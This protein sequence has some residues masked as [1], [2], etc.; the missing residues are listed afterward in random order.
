MENNTNDKQES[1]YTELSLDNIVS[2]SSQPRTSFNEERL[3]ELAESIKRNGIIQ[4]IIVR[5]Y[6]K[7]YE[8]IAGERRYRAAK[9]ANLTT[10][11]AIIRDCENQQS[12]EF[13]LIENVQRDDLNPLEEAL[14]YKKLIDDYTYKHEDISNIIGKSRSYISNYL[15][16]LTLPDSIKNYLRDGKISMGHAKLLVNLENS[17]KI[18][19]EIIKKSLNVRQ[20]ESL[21]KKSNTDLI[22]ND[23]KKSDEIK[24]LEEKLSESLGLKI[25]ITDNNDKYGSVKVI[26]NNLKELE[27]ILK[28]LS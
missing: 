17:E 4:P 26:F 3:L 22:E 28:K 14:A 11:P 8:I 9:L 20:T 16:I 12:S 7:Q 27:V 10:I 1:H 25:I 21:I 24:L 23:N 6:G 13:A 2:N 19:D 5:Q 15:R 18:A